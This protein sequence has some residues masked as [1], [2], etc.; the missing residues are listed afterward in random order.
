MTNTADHQTGYV[1]DV[2]FSSGYVETLQ[3]ALLSHVAAAGGFSAPD[4]SGTYRY[5]ELGCSNGVTLNGLAASNPQSTFVGI[6]FN[7]EHIALAKHGA[8]VAD[9]HNVQYHHSDFRDVG[10]LDLPQF[11]YVAIH[12]AYSWLDPGAEDAVHSIVDQVLTDNGVFFVDYMSMPGKAPIAPIWHLLRTLADGAYENSAERALDGFGQLSELVEHNAGFF[13]NNPHAKT[14]HKAWTNT[15]QMQPNAPTRL[16]HN[17]LTDNWRPK[18]FGEVA[19]TCKSIGL[20]FAGSTELRM[21]DKDLSLPRALQMLNG[22][23]LD[24]I[25][26][27]TVKDFFHY[28]QQRNDVYA[29][30]AKSEDVDEGLF[31][32]SSHVASLWPGSQPTWELQGPKGEAIETNPQLFSRAFGFINEGICGTKELAEALVKDGHSRKDA[33]TTVRRMLLLPEFRVFA[34]APLKI[35]PV[36]PRAVQALNRYNELAIASYAKTGGTL[37]L[38]SERLGACVKLPELVSVVTAAFVGHQIDELSIDQVVQFVRTVPGAYATGQGRQV[39]GA[40]IT[41]EMISPACDLVRALV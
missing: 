24:A 27:E 19:E 23:E 3:P 13:A 39:D 34:R 40:N 5:L 16:A 14:V 25:K 1:Q 4:S 30:S 8:Q 41:R 38:S 2:T 28:S 6:D 21:N 20:S 22:K 33:A 12:G 9:L 17:A 35:E 31:T 18:Y 37:V 11:E 29:R 15:L 26:L 32:A 7:E 36:P 10:A